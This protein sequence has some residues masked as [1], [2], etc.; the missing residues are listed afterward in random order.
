MR[1]LLGVLHGLLQYIF[2]LDA[3]PSARLTH[4]E[5][6]VYTATSTS[7]VV[8]EREAQAAVSEVVLGCP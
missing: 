7:M 3:T 6:Y 1:Q 2:E 5:A 4:D 8:V